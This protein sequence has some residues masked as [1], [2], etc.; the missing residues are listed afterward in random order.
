[1]PE[2]RY[3]VVDLKIDRRLRSRGIENNQPPSVNPAWSNLANVYE[4]YF[5]RLRQPL[6]RLTKPRTLFHLLHKRY[7]WEGHL[8]FASHLSRGLNYK[9]GVLWFIYDLEYLLYNC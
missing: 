9:V 4:D 2:N 5:N 7:Y 1:M 3:A 6:P 8:T